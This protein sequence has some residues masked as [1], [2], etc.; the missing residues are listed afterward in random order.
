MPK[1]RRFLPSRLEIEGV[2]PYRIPEYERAGMLRLD[3]N[4]NPAGAPDFVVDAVVE[5]LRGQE[6][7]TYPVYSEWQAEAADYFGV[8]ADRIT[9][10]S[11]G[12]EGIK[13]IFDT[14]L[15]PGTAMLTLA[16]GY[17]MFRLW[18]QLLGN[19][20]AEVPLAVHG[21]ANLRFDPD[22]WLAALS[23]ADD[24]PPIGLIAV[25]NPSNPTGAAIPRHIIEQTLELVDCPVIIDETYGE[26]L[27]ETAL[28]LVDKHRHLF[29]TRSFSKVYGLAGLRIGVVI[30]QPD[31]IEGLRRVLNP[32]NVNRAAIAA[33]IACMRHAEHTSLHVVEVGDCRTRFAGAMRG[34]GLATGAEHGNFLLVHFGDQ[35]ARVVDGLAAEGILVRDRH[36]KHADL[37]GCVR[38]AIGSEAQMQRVSGAI[39]RLVR[40]PPKLDGLIL[41]VDGT[42]VDVSG[43]YRRAVVDTARALLEEAGL[44]A[45]AACIDA[46]LVDEYKARGGL[47]NDWEC[48]HAMV[49][50]AGLD[51]PL[52]QVIEHFQARYLGEGFDGLIADEPWLLESAV[53]ERLLSALPTAVVTGR[54]RSE[55]VWTLQR[56]AAPRLWKHLLAMEDTP[57]AKPDPAG[58][59]AA[60]ES[61]GGG[62]MAYVGDGVDDMRAARSAGMAAYG[63][64]PPGTG[65]DS[66]WPEHLYAAGADAVFANIEEVIAW[67]I[68]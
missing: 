64:L 22:A 31:N 62:A 36:G 58:L 1:S 9:C 5:A 3:I 19:P 52:E 46:A 29:V 54:P 4:E 61:L 38:I 21:P 37:A 18:A 35:H 66:G 25:A 67:L 55:A 65:W 10:T 6:I 27:G 56:H 57:T 17:D 20:V 23:P 15:L 63:V 30:S 32:F 60:R 33:S 44:S 8:A 39:G 45:A 42:L 40:P 14:H 34:L 2:S 12:D 47:N 51:V 24:R 68:P 48:T 13:A 43:S 50:E 28:D 49:C 11:G 16:P 53:E 59:V 41:D 7:A 26:F